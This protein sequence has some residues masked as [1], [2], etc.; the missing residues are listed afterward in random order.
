LLTDV[1]M[2]ISSYY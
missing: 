1:D 2:W